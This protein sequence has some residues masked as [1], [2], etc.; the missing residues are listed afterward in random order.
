MKKKYLIL[1]VIF[2][3]FNCSKDDLDTQKVIVNSLTPINTFIGDT[4]T[5]TGQN[6]LT[7]KMITLFNKEINTNYN[8]NK[9]T[10]FISK[11]AT[12]IKFIVPELYH[13]NVTVTTTGDNPEIEI[14]LFG[15]IPYS[16]QHNSS[17]FRKAEVRQLVSD[18]LVI[19]ESETYFLE[20]FKLTNNLTDYNPLP[21]RNANDS[22]FYYTSEHS[23]WI[24]ARGIKYKSYD[25][26]SFT[27]DINN[28]KFEY[29]ILGEDINGER[30]AYMEFVSPDLA[31]M[32]NGIGE[33]YQILNGQ[34]ISFYDIYPELNNS[35]Y[36]SDNYSK[37]AVSFQVLEDN[38]ILISP[39]YQ[40]Y[41]LRF[42]DANVT[43]I[44]FESIVSNSYEN[45]VS[46]PTFFGNTGA[47]YSNNKIFKSTDY[48]LTW[49]DHP[50]DVTMGMYDGI[51]FL[52]GS[53]FLFHDGS[54]SNDP[55]IR[56]KYISTDN[57][58]SWKLIF[59]SY[60]FIR[61]LEISDQYGIANSG[62][63]GSYGLVKFRKFPIGF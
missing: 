16:K 34:I 6:L 20:R 5:L 1:I 10:H 37:Y 3:F 53:Q 13:E 36:M 18:D 55:S 27:D 2:S 7:L 49:N 44:N 17:I 40:N 43:T 60:D 41:I 8:F 51:Q 50:I 52:G 59:S 31:Y 11:T 30:I 46:E 9:V 42:S 33:M 54:Y 56:H 29:R 24:V 35:P 48:G 14:Q 57:G 28:R 38:S 39:W 63:F 19:L 15:F 47:F 26:Y 32:M 4:L 62:P 21:L 22:F 61:D 23:G 25:V 45:S 58:V 12:E